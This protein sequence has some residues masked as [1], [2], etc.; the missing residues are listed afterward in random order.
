MSNHLSRRNW[1]KKS[2]VSTGG[3]IAGISTAT[4][5]SGFTSFGMK[6]TYVNGLVDHSDLPLQDRSLLKARLTSNE[7]PFGPSKKTIAAIAEAAAKGNRYPMDAGRKMIETLA[8]KEGV[9]QEQIIMAAGSSDILEKTAFMLCAKGGNVVSADPSYMSLIKSATALGATWKNIP[10]RSDYAHDLAAMEKAVDA[11]TKLVYICNPNNPTGTLTPIEELRAFCKRVSAK[12][13]VFV[14]E[15]Y[16]ELLDDHDKQS[17]VGLILEGH[18]IIVCRTFSKIHGMAGLRMGYAVAKKER[19]E[20][21][22]GAGRAGMGLSVTTLEGAMASLADIEFQN[23]S[24]TNIKINRDYTMQE[25]K[26]ANLQPIPS[27]T[28]FILFPIEMPTRV[29]VDAM[30]KM[31]VGMR[32]FDINGKPFGRVSIGT[33]DEMKLFSKCLAE[34]LS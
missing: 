8:T 5:A 16:L 30:M 10:L 28:N 12:V 34:T 19:I 4:Q 26:K 29:L 15:A 24:R 21:L 14:D 3:L 9:A 1:L 25:L 20:L 18:D 27:F 2:L 11:D 31:G 6:P 23:Y 33:M 7:N 17:T 13:P 32:G 22:Q